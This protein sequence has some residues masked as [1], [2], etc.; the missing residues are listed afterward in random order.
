MATSVKVNPTQSEPQQLVLPTRNLSRGQRRRR[1]AVMTAMCVIAITGLVVVSILDSVKAREKGIRLRNLQSSVNLSI[2]VAELVHRLQIERGSRVMLGSSSGDASVDEKVQ[3]AVGLTDEVAKNLD[4]WPQ[5]LEKYPF[6]SKDTFMTL[7]NNHRHGI[8]NSTIENEILF[9]SSII[10]NLFN[11]SFQNVLLSDYDDLPKFISYEILLMGKE[12]TGIER[13]LGGSYFIQGHF[14][15]TEKLLW[16]AKE[17]FLGKEKINFS[18]TLEPR[19]KRFYHKAL[20]KTLLSQIEEKREVILSNKKQVPSVDSGIEWFDL[21]TIYI[22]GLLDVQQQ[23]GTLILEEVKDH[24]SE[25]DRDSILKLLVFGFVVLI[26]MPFFVYSVYTIQA[27]AAKLHRITKDLKEEKERAD[28]LLYQMLP[29]P[30]AEQLKS[31]RNVTAEQ[32]ESVT[33]FFSDIVNFTQICASIS[34]MKVTQML[35]W[36]YGLF[37]NQIDKYD[38][39]KVETIG[40]AYMVVSGLPEPNQDHVVQ[41]ASMA[42]DLVGLMEGLSPAVSEIER[43]HLCV[44]IGIHTGKFYPEPKYSRGQKYIKSFQL[45]YLLE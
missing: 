27:Y 16:F 26:L 28:T 25:S 43:G 31:G 7:L 29:H 45:P 41:I 22:D 42:L 10:S 11:W 15:E 14:N 44:R 6:N 21:M 8:K 1:I 36:L 30:V 17:N 19:M 18:L 38:V 40:D 4:T 37:D 20:N 24:V 5:D 2:K 35:N 39:Y 33:V 9:Y 12:K 13:A 3:D 32:F 34:P 23:L